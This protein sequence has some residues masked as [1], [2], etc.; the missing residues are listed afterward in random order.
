[1]LRAEEPLRLGRSDDDE[2]ISLW[3]LFRALWAGRVRIAVAAVIG[4]LLCLGIAFVIPPIYEG[5]TT[6]VP[7]PQKNS[8][9]SLQAAAMPGD[10]GAL[11]GEPPQRMMLYPELIRSRQSLEAALAA[12]FPRAS[13]QDSVLLIDL[14][15]RSGSGALR[16]EN[17]VKKLRRKVYATIDR[18]TSML[19]IRVRSGDPAV[20]ASVANFL[21]AHLQE[22]S[23]RSMAGNAAENR[24]F[25]EGRL[26]ET[27]AE[28]ARAEAALETF[29]QNNLRIGNSPHLQLQQGRLMRDVRVQ[30]EVFLTLTREYELARV[31]EHRDVPV[32]NTIDLAIVPASRMWPRRGLL[33]GLGGLFGLVAGAVLVL[34]R[35]RTS[36]LAQ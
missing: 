17:A 18:R 11:L 9:L 2:S 35:P 3:T 28:L 34:A 21:V 26:A 10:L 25:V 7:V 13:G 16:L 8:R 27:S 33:A 1:L 19:T 36:P 15:E 14:V 4:S 22:F 23:I 29:N 30:E 24:R 12:R 31:D 32:V 6:A 5:V 20:A